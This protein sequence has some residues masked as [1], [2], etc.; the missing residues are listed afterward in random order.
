MKA[1]LNNKN[2]II[3]VVE[4]CSPE[5]NYIETNYEF[6]VDELRKYK[7][8]EFGIPRYYLQGDS[9]KKRTDTTIKKQPAFNLYQKRMREQ[10]FI[11]ETDKLEKIAK[12]VEITQGSEA[13]E[14]YY[15]TWVNAKN[16]IR[17]KYPYYEGDE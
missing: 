3:T 1:I 5:L 12:E 4:G 15:L 11:R 8:Y 10:E 9:I 14:S 17:A 13:A 16:D 6:E 2:E 7:L